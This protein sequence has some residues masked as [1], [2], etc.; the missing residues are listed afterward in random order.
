MK[1]TIPEISWHNRDPVLSIDIQPIKPDNDGP[2]R[3]AS[4]GTD[5]HVVIWHVLIKSDGVATVDFAADLQRHQRAVNV[6]RFSPS[7]EFLA[8]GDDESAI[9]IWKQ[10]TD[11]DT[12][13]FPS[14]ESDANKE[15]WLTVRILRGHVEDVYDLSWSLDSSN[16]ISGSMDNSAILWD[17]AKGRNIGILKDHGGFVQGVTWDP[18]NKY[19]ATLSSDRM[20]RVYNVNTK[21]IVCRMSKARLPV[22]EGSPLEGKVVRLFHD[23][24]LKSFFRRLSFSP[25]GEIL[26]APTGFIEIP[27]SD[28]HCNATYIFTRSELNKPVVYL[29]SPNEYTVAVRFCP[30]LF[31]L[32]E[33]GSMFALP[34]R[35]VVAVATQ[36]SV[37]LYDTQQPEPFGIISNIH[38][39]RLTDL[40]WS[41]D[42]RLLMISSTD[43]YCSIVV[44]TPGELGKVYIPK[45]NTEQKT[46]PEAV[47]TSVNGAVS[48]STDLEKVKDNSAVTS[49]ICNSSESSKGLSDNSAASTKMDCDETKES[50]K[51]KATDKKVLGPFN[52]QQGKADTQAKASSEKKVGRRIC[53]IA[54]PKSSTSGSEKGKKTVN[55]QEQP[56]KISVD[57]KTLPDKASEKVTP[58]VELL[59]LMDTST[60][61]ATALSDLEKVVLGE[62]E[63]MIVDE[64]TQKF[65]L[66]LEPPDEESDR[67]MEVEECQDV[68]GK[69]GTKNDSKEN[70]NKL[71]QD[72]SNGSS[73]EGKTAVV[74]KSKDLS[75]ENKSETESRSRRIPVPKLPPSPT[76]KDKLDESSKTEI[77]S[78]KT[79]ELEVPGVKLTPPVKSKASSVDLGVEDPEKM[80]TEKDTG[81]AVD[82][83][84][85]RSAKEEVKEPHQN[86]PNDISS[87]E[88]DKTGSEKLST[89]QN[90]SS[91]K[92]GPEK[93]TDTESED[94]VVKEKVV[95]SESSRTATENSN[96]ESLHTTPRKSSSVACRD[97]NAK[98]FGT[99]SDH[100]P[101]VSSSHE[102]AKPSPVTPGAN[103][104]RTPRRVQFI[105]ISSPRSKKK[106]L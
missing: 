63:K 20:C 51:E 61:E 77:V 29:P 35:M 10:K 55:L 2:Y 79:E 45:E 85:D 40:C 8:S 65:S 86:H 7:G 60:S 62:R 76:S 58:S 71:K 14:S 19:V 33:G 15:Q 54:V 31:E 47:D 27:D 56:K 24:T 92:T 91:E 97:K 18:K 22:P 53:P 106:L 1:C 81:S 43:G 57:E 93:P 94:T 90:T 36:C 70:V 59:S 83:S 82:Q 88:T 84:E 46:N 5:S 6:V 89:S 98:D 74:T 16:L 17:V 101:Q 49:A 42:G 3:L 11:Q 99:S 26:V 21:K 80:I 67:K 28:K 37:V 78:M 73:V 64:D 69:K 41:S 75:G 87:L 32:H 95:S 50:V 23:D 12:P 96:E 34:Y 104:K 38:Y 100:T 39:T 66:V 72:I 44:F 48:G 52:K 105:T 103:D 4:G 68:S 30:L 102:D 9:I 25:D 13:E